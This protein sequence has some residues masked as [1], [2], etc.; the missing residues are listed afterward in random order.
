MSSVWYHL[1]GPARVDGMTSSPVVARPPLR[2]V[3]GPVAAPALRPVA[4]AVALL[5]TLLAMIDFFIVNVALP[6]LAVDLD[7]SGAALEL[8]VSGYATAYAVLLVVGGRL[9]DA[10]GR[11][12]LFVLG[13]AAFTATSL[14]CGLA[15]TAATL[16]AARVLQG[17]AAALMVPQ[18]LS[19]IQATGDA[20][21]RARAIG[22]FGATGGIAAVVGQVLGGVL[23]DADLAGSQWRPIFL[24]N[25]PIGLAGLWLA[26]TRLPETR[27]PRPARPDVAGTVLLAAA[28]V[29]VLLPLT[30]G[31]AAGWP[32]WSVLLLA[33]APLWIGAFVVT[34]RVLEGRGRT[35]LLPPSILR[36]R[37]MR[38]GLALAA[39]FFAGFGAFMFVYA[40]LV[41][42]ALGWS[43]TLAGLAL[44]PM[45]GT[46]LAASLLMPRAVARWGRSVVTGGAAVQLVGLVGLG[47]TIAAAWPRVG[48]LELA[49]WLAVAGFGQGLV[50]PSLIRIVLSDV[51]VASAGV[52]SGVLTTTQQVS[53][54]VG[55]AGLGSLFLTLGG[56]DGTGVLRAV[57][58]ILAVQALVALG[59]VIG[60][61]G[62]PG[63]S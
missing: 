40:L 27:S 3:P 12:R 2:S 33:S 35:P 5:G 42:G 21:S 51:P 1:G 57:L 54:A 45:A 15:P 59:I 31:R 46:F 4:L 49:P 56:P 14:L 48:V 32:L 34:E 7:A 38:R 58:T 18:T 28:V 60:S 36:H 10:F 43:P 24:V 47:V 9:G 39:P 29:A 44:T 55:V 13:M 6:T 25:V 62:L 20:A 17:A 22:W 19:T 37:S 50:M 61:R 26:R 8:V 41:Q 16:V 53:L 11:R 23:V 63:R 52:G 30:E